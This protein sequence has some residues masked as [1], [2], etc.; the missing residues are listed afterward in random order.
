MTIA[1]YPGTFDPVT[2]GHVDIACRAAS[3]FDKLIVAVYDT[4][5]KHL[6]FT[7][8][9][10]VQLFHD[11]VKSAKNIEVRPYRGLTVD[12]A[13]QVGAKVVIRGLRM[14]SDFEHEFEMA[15]MNKKLSP[16][17]ELFCLMSSLEYQFL[18]SSLLKEVAHLGGNIDS[19]VP[20]GVAKALY[21]KIPTK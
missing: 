8:E 20:G 6:M 2:N 3:L 10:R 12:Y 1:V 13:R 21:K 19:M 16:D 18:S 7:T 17:L 15:L 9:E 14:S 4:S 5:P 11:S